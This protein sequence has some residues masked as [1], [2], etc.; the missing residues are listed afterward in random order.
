MAAVHIPGRVIGDGAPCF[1]IAEA[2][3]NHN[4]SLELA[5]ELVDIAAD[6]GADAV[7]FQTFRAESVIAAGAPKAGYQTRTTD[8]A[9]SQL[10]M[11]RRLE[12]KRE[13]HHPLAKR[14]AERGIIFI[15]TAFDE[16]SAGFLKADVRVPLLKIPS[17]EV[18]NAPLLLAF[19]RLGLPMILSTG[20]STS[21]DVETALGVLA[22]GLLGRGE[23][24]SAAAFRDAFLSGLGHKVLRDNVV[25]LHCTS[26]YPAAFEETNLLAMDG[27]R[28]S[29]GLAVGLSDHTPGIA[30]PIAAAARGAAVIEKHFTLD[31]AMPGPDH[32]ASIEPGDLK[33]MVA[34]VR[35]AE[36][37]LGAADKAPTRAELANRPIVRRSLV[38]ARAIAK[39][40]AFTQDNVTA[41]RPGTGMD[42]MR[43]W[44]LLGRKA[45]RDYQ[46]DS[47][48]SER[49]EF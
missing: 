49:D 4:G 39:G 44:E 27:M 15:S 20:M 28:E 11:V 42:P 38:A 25:L 23:R 24:P 34:G 7:K 1:V 16:G 48:I 45:R 43:Y 40:E 31:R 47:P 33:A 26:E 2:G 13:Y 3:V 21:S 37:A 6:A 29:F 14:C 12:L 41:K 8:P 10:E 35:A 19:A 46:A 9:E 5:L 18:T 30:I 22:F 36:A 32:K 17:G